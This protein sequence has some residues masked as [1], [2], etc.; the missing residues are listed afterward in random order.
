MTALRLLILCLCLVC[1]R[2]AAPARA[3]LHERFADG[4]LER[5]PSWQRF[6]PGWV[7]A[8]EGA[9]FAL[10]TAGGPAADT[11]T[12]STESHVAYGRWSLRFGYRDLNLSNANGARIYL[13]ADAPDL[14]GPVRGYYLQIGTNNADEVRLY[15]QDGLPEQRTLLGGAAPEALRQRSADLT[16][17]ATRGPEG[18]WQVW[19][20]GTLAFS[21]HDDAHRWGPYFGLWVKHSAAAGA[22]YR[23]DDL[24]AEPLAADAAPPRLLLA[25]RAAPTAVDATFD[26]PLLPSSAVPEAFRWGEQRPL[27]LEMLTERAYRLHFGAEAPAEALLRVEGVRD[28][29]GNRLG[30]AHAAVAPPPAPGELVFN[31]I[32]YAPRTGQSEYVEWE[33]AAAG[34]RYLYGLYLED[35]AGGKLPLAEG[36][37]LAPGRGFVV[38]RAAGGGAACP[39][40][41][42]YTLARADLGLNDGGDRL[43]LRLPGGGLVDEAAYAPA[44][45]NPFLAA[46]A[47][48]S[49][50]RAEGGAWS[51]SVDASGGTPGCPNS[52]GGA[53]EAGALRVEVGPVPFSPDGDGFEDVLMVRFAGAQRGGA[54][55]ARIYDLGGRL[56]RT[57]T[58][59]TPAPAAGQFDWDGLDDAG[60]ALPLGLYVLLFEAYGPD[61]AARQARRVLALAAPHS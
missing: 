36:P 20:D 16:L 26:E 43:A 48:V 10:H 9:D 54:V 7:L 51:S 17:E 2:L 42:V 44:Q 39:E 14:E 3:Q 28:R 34:P 21:A 18:A 1:L 38:L 35:A 22:A 47:G 5:D 30:Q 13:V 4:E 6:Q 50:E 12:I 31:E 46:T 52:L 56:V 45:H 8:P 33:N 11:L 15:R 29:Y 41:Y 57:L 58:P 27:R 49:L 55:R 19:V 23:F 24:F 37:A 60:R 59:A 40:A 25:G 53:E 32:L 61:G